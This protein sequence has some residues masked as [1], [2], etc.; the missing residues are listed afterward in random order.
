M[1]VFLILNTM[2]LVMYIELIL[3]CF[4]LYKTLNALLFKNKYISF[5]IDDLSVCTYC[6]LFL[7]KHKQCVR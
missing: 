6:E 5:S 1:H 2:P 4:E 7:K 3:S